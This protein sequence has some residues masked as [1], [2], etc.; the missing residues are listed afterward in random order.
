MKITGSATHTNNSIIILLKIII[1]VGFAAS[2]YAAQIGFLTSSLFYASKITIEQQIM[3]LVGAAIFAVIMLSL[4]FFW[5]SL[6]KRSIFVF[7][8]F[9][10]IIAGLFYLTE[11]KVDGG[12]G[13]F[14]YIDTYVVIISVF[15]SAALYFSPTLM[16]IASVVIAN[17]I[18]LLLLWVITLPFDLVFNLYKK[19]NPETEYF[20]EDEDF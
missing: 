15:I 20:Y 18:S 5:S 13:I 7:L 8:L 1:S 19:K 6:S 3:L 12:I 9:L 2:V 16:V 17:I 14:L 10:K 11:D 4:D